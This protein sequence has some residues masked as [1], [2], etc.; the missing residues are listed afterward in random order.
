MNSSYSNN[1]ESRQ[2][3]ELKPN[4]KIMSNRNQK[5][6]KLDNPDTFNETEEQKNNINDLSVSK[7]DS[8][9]LSM[10]LHDL[11]MEIS[12][13]NFHPGVYNMVDKMKKKPERETRAKILNK[14]ILSPVIEKQEDEK[15]NRVNEEVL[16]QMNFEKKIE[17]KKE[18]K[19]KEKIEIDK[20]DEM[21]KEND[22][23]EKKRDDE[24][25]MDSVM[26]QK[27]TFCVTIN[28]ED[29]NTDY[30]DLKNL[31]FCKKDKSSSVS[32]YTPTSTD[33]ESNGT[34]FLFN[35]LIF[36]LNYNFKLFYY[37]NFRFVY[38]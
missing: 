29:G 32:S 10:E 14:K 16:R 37:I 30:N 3:S 22:E 5:E 11:S 4:E 26:E 34:I 6:K 36:F 12:N 35:V 23:E 33:E 7:E 19:I 15:Q 38:L 18:D 1:K 8:F 25:P 17:E 28:E 31:T 24:I 21:I 9:S 2:L 27:N 13:L 20:K